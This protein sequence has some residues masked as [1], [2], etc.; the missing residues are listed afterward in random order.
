MII[1]QGLVYDERQNV[2][3]PPLPKNLGPWNP[4][5]PGQG[6]EPMDDTPNAIIRHVLYS[7]DPSET[8]EDLLHSL[9]YYM[10]KDRLR[11]RH[12]ILIRERVVFLKRA[13]VY[14]VEFVY[15]MPDVTSV[16]YKLWRERQANGGYTRAE[17]QA[18]RQAADER[19]ADYH[20]LRWNPAKHRAKKRARAQAKAQA[21][22][23]KTTR[24]ADRS[25]LWPLQASS[26]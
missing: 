6:N 20:S 18:Q 14:A 15:A 5:L 23:R 25:S 13:R 16:E 10:I 21:Q 26:H 4:P 9:A 17:R 11:Y 8:K 24:C 1:Q 12:A 7:R 19:W 22:M 2:I 3:V